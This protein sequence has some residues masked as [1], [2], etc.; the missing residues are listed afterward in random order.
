MAAAAANDD[1]SNNKM[2][3]VEMQIRA[4]VLFSQGW[5]LSYSQTDTKT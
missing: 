3:S 1:D 4:A 2:H 5:D